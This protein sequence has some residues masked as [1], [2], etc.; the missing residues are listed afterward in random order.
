MTNG[1][2]RLPS[3]H[4]CVHDIVLVMRF[5]WKGVKRNARVNQVLLLLYLNAAFMQPSRMIAVVAFGAP[6][7]CIRC[8]P[9]TH[10]VRSLHAFGALPPPERGRVGVGVTALPPPERGMVGVGVTERR[11]HR[12]LVHSLHLKGGGWGVATAIADACPGT[13]VASKPCPR[14]R[15]RCHASPGRRDPAGPAA[16]PSNRA[17]LLEPGRAPQFCPEV[18]ERGTVEAGFRGQVKN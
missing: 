5:I 9:S 16:G 12:A 10:S 18:K 6:P 17:S 8:T 14:T 15:W 3:V 7:P 2:D 11:P 1:R 4:S 13:S